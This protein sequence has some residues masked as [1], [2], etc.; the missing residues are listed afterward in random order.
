MPWYVFLGDLDFPRPDGNLAAFGHGI[1]GIDGQIN[2]GLFEHGWIR[3]NGQ[4]FVGEVAPDGD[5]FSQHRPEHVANIGG[6]DIKVL[7]FALHDLLTA[8]SQHLADEFGRPL[9]AGGDLVEGLDRIVV[10]GRIVQQQRAVALN[11]GENIVE[12]VGHASGHLAD[13]G[14]ALLTHGH[15]LAFDE[16]LLRLFAFG[17][18]ALQTFGPFVDELE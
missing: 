16:C 6:D 17:H 8:E 1:A 13:G 2:Q 15:F 9:D 5:A 10:Q 11:D 18:F 7:C 3:Q 4:R 14:E 12:A